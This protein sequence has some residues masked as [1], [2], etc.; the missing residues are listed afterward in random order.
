GSYYLA[1]RGM[2]YSNGVSFTFVRT[3]GKVA[4]KKIVGECSLSDG[5]LMDMGTVRLAESDFVDPLQKIGTAYISG[6]DKG[7]VFWVNPSNPL[8]GKIVSV[9]KASKKAF[10]KAKD[11]V[12]S[13][14]TAVGISIKKEDG[15]ENVAKIKE[16]ELYKSGNYNWAID[17]CEKEADF[18]DGGWYLPSS[19]ELRLVLGAIHG[20]SY[21]DALALSGTPTIE[22]NKTSRDKFLAA[23][24]TCGEA[25]ES[26]ASE[27]LFV[28]GMWSSELATDGN[29]ALYVQI[30]APGESGAAFKAGTNNVTNTSNVRCIKKVSL[31]Y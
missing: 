1:L 30:N 28:G 10:M 18:Q 23:M 25:D 3:D 11:G 19:S 13:P 15:S 14:A 21:A 27:S 7:V 6:N 2:K 12:E 9:W 26:A 5:D 16:T 4:V 17:E 29:K 24:V 8:E 22:L 20:L 31:S